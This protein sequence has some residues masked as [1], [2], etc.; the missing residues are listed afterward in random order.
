MNQQLNV[1]EDTSP[2]DKRIINNNRKR[3]IHK[4]NWQ[5]NIK[6]QLKKSGK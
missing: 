2:V 4:E 3:L 5:K 6:K 1:V